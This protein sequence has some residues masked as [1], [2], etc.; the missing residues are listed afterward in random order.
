V[1]QHGV[2]KQAILGQEPTIQGKTEP[3]TTRGTR[4]SVIDAK[5]GGKKSSISDQGPRSQDVVMEIFSLKNTPK[6]THSFG[7]GH[8][9]IRR[10]VAKTAP[11]T[12]R[13]TSPREQQ[14]FN[15]HGL[16]PS[17]GLL[18]DRSQRYL[19]RHDIRRT[20][21][22]EGERKWTTKPIIARPLGDAR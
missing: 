3:E 20:P 16:V 10:K 2:V 9:K 11:Q 18:S 12:G 13:G 6:E 4:A 15:L 7:R 21:E 1:K 8:A 17:R 5:T 14:N 19:Y 22:K